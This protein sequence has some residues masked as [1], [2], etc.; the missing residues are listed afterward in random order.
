MW[1]SVLVCLLPSVQA[2]TPFDPLPY[3]PPQPPALEGDLAPNED[4]RLAESLG[5]GLLG[6]SEDLAVD[7]R[8][9][10]HG[11]TE[12]GRILRL[13]VSPDGEESVEVFAETGGR[14]LGLH[15]DAAE[16]LIVADAMKGLLSVDPTGTITV[17]STSADS[18]PFR[19]TEDV[20]IA[21]DGRIYFSDASSKWG[22][23]ETVLDLFEGRPHGRLLRFD[24]RT[25]E[26]EVLL[27]GLYFANG[28][29]L[30]QDEDFVIVCETAR[31]RITRY[32]IVG[33]DAGTSDIFIDNLPG[34]PDG[35][36]GNGNG[37]FY[38]ALLGVR[39]ALVDWLQPRP[40]L[41]T[42]LS[43]LPNDFWLDALE[44]Y[45]FAL[46]LDENGNVIR[47]L[48]DPGGD[49]VKGVSSV[50]QLGDYLYLT[51]FDDD[52]VWRL[53]LSALP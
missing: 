15:F 33:P 42:L 43:F 3:E 18:V 12:D 2:C 37:T 23:E 4:L 21:A 50:E 48:Q 24:P 41:K 26:T 6:T 30:S 17:L 28:V 40:A 31:Y 38:V 5:I 13:T 53:P 8:D 19:F 9:R 45:G 46:A 49:V 1:W 27:D 32:W 34:F 29:A 14:P 25:D 20:D 35:V 47:T 51:F 11:G 44:P 10:I 16:N 52:R 22:I 39:N 7:R 36:S